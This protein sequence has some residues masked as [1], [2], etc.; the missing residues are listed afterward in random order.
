MKSRKRDFMIF[1]IVILAA[2]L[3]VWGSLFEFSHRVN[4]KLQKHAYQTL[5]NAAADQNEAVNMR[6]DGKFTLLNTMADF[7]GDKVGITHE[8]VK[9]V[10]VQ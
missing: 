7:L 9:Q 10:L 5:E 3:L 4:G 8:E 6:I 2:G 1:I